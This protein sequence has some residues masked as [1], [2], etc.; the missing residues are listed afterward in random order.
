MRL[1]ITGASGNLGTALLRRLYDA[2]VHVVG[3]CRRPP[4]AEPPYD[5]VRWLALD[6]ADA[7]SG[8]ALVHA[9]RGADAV[10][11]LAWV[12]QPS[13]DLDYQQR[14][15]LGGT[16]RVLD[17]VTRGRVAHL[18][19]ASSLAAYAPGPGDRPVDETWPTTG[20]P[21]LTYSR[22]KAAAE[23]MLDD[24]ERSPDAPSVT[25]VRPNLVLQSA[26]GSQLLRYFVGPFVPAPLLPRLPAA[27]LPRELRF[28]AVHADDV[29]DALLRILDRRAGGAFN[30][31]AEPVLD[32][33]SLA[34]ALGAR[35][36][37]VPVALAR[38]VAAAAWHARLQPTAPGWVD[39]GVL[40]PL[41]DTTRAREVL[42]WSPA[43]TGEEALTELVAGMAERAGT[44]SPALRPRGVV[45]SVAEAT[46]RVRRGLPRRPR[47]RS[48]PAT[49]PPTGDPR[50]RR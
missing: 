34:R 23:R 4:D 33:G 29:A 35:L 44:A 32:A 21:S 31:A 49:S 18:V 22:H 50:A 11:H 8:P 48:V 28:Q 15:N 17:A 5:R 38:P 16:R 12:I 42:G 13:R 37:P 27:P 41:L 3:V 25:R 9:A 7:D 20:I 47:R 14:G 6:L 40:A 2:D 30:F 10:V 43:H 46:A 24:L 45:A 19:H 26:A 36:V 39:L 1:L